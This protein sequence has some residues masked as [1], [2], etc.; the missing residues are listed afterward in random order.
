M[1]HFYKCIIKN[2]VAIMAPIIKLTR[3]TIFS[4]DR[5]ISEG[6]GIDYIKVYWSIDIDI[7]KLAG[8]ISCSYR[9]VLVSYGGYVVSKR[10]REP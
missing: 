7:T 9:C 5:G 2:F 8:G 1:A 3:K 4:F 6:L 10:N